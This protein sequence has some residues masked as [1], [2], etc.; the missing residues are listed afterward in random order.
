LPD[1][2]RV[3]AGSRSTEVINIWCD[4]V[5][6]LGIYRQK[7][8]MGHFVPKFSECPS[9]ETTDLIQKNQGGCKMVRTSTIFIQSLVEIRRCTVA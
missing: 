3:Y 7:N 2:R 1:V 6:K 8:A 9:S 5:G 4:S